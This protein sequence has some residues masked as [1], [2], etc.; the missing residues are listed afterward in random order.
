MNKSII[1][2]NK[3]MKYIYRKGSTVS[4]DTGQR[5]TTKS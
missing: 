1:D 5:K 2:T 3:E 4:K